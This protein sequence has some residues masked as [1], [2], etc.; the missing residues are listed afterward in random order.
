MASEQ[1]S[2]SGGRVPRPTLRARFW[3]ARLVR[4]QASRERAFAPAICEATRF[5]RAER[6]RQ[7]ER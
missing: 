3:T 6:L 2:V 1:G 7:L 5:K 4:I